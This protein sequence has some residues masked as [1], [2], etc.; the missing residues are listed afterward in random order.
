VARTKIDLVE[1]LAREQEFPL[2]LTMEAEE[3]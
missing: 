2:S 3:I 1:A